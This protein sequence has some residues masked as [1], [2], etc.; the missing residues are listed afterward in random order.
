MT[1]ENRRCDQRHEALILHTEVVWGGLVFNLYTEADVQA[2]LANVDLFVSFP[3][4][5]LSCVHCNKG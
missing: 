5:P 2:K 3:S 1:W 4:L